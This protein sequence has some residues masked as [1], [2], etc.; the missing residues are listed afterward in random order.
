[1]KCSSL[2]GCVD[3]YAPPSKS[4]P[5]CKILDCFKSIGATTIAGLLPS[6]VG[7]FIRYV[8]A[9]TIQI[10]FK[11]DSFRIYFRRHVHYLVLCGVSDTV[12][13]VLPLTTTEAFIQRIFIVGIEKSFFF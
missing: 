12:V 1:M 2:L 10:S 5:L 6:L 9:L 3:C 8:F 11:V 13:D 4:P 7:A